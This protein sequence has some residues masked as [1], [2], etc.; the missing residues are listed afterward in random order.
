MEDNVNL[1]TTPPNKKIVQLQQELSPFSPFISLFVFLFLFLLFPFESR[2][3]YSVINNVRRTLKSRRVMKWPIWGTYAHQSGLASI[4]FIETVTEKNGLVAYFF[5]ICLCL[6]SRCCVTNIHTHRGR[7]IYQ[8]ENVIYGIVVINHV[9]GAK[10]Y[11]S[12]VLLAVVA[13]EK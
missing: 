10:S 11:N 1:T 7:M 8:C 4:F 3:F 5:C 13:S 9:L 12:N 2:P 6:F